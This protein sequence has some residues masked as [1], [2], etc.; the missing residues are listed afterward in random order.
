MTLPGAMATNNAFAG[1]LLIGVGFMVGVVL[2]LGFHREDFLGGYGSWQRRLLR[3]GHI[4]CIALGMLNI[5]FDIWAGNRDSQ[6]VG[7]SVASFSWIAG[8]ITMPL[9]CF[10]AAWRPEI[11][12]L[13]F[14]P[15]TLL[16]IAAMSTLGIAWP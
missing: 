16:V 1:W 9:V 11:R 2:G 5:L 12:Y 14:V 3:L 6:Q 4:A 15:V 13:F 10:L 7:L 8:G